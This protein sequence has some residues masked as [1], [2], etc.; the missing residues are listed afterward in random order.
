MFLFMFG[1][2]AERDASCGP[3]VRSIFIRKKIENQIVSHRKFNKIWKNENTDL[4]ILVNLFQWREDSSFRSG[5][6]PAIQRW[7]ACV[8]NRRR[9]DSQA[10]GNTGKSPPNRRKNAG[11][12]LSDRRRCYFLLLAPGVLRSCHPPYTRW[13]RLPP[14]SPDIQ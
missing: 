6:C 12:S 13:K 14:L 11:Q 8:P 7:L 9:I 5:D 1:L 4:K 3:V 10:I 2:V